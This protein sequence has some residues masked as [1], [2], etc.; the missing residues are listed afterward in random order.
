MK[1]A[2][3]DYNHKAILLEEMLS[4]K[5]TDLKELDLV[6]ELI[7]DI[8]RKYLKLKVNSIT[9]EIIEEKSKNS[10]YPKSYNAGAK[11]FKQKLLQK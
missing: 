1:L 2:A 9:D 7:M 6:C 5:F 8:K 11:W 3:E 10:H 4:S